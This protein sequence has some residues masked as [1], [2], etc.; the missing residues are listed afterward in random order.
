MADSPIKAG[1]GLLC[2]EVKTN[3]TPLPA[4]L[5]IQALQVSRAVNQIPTAT[6]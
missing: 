3:G 4:T 2:V 1:D 6:V 5:P